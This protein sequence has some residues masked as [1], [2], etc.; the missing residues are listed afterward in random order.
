MR[1]DDNY[2]RSRAAGGLSRRRFLSSTAVGAAAVATLGLVGC[3]DDDNSESG[4]GGTS[5]QSPSATGTPKTASPKGQIQPTG[6][7][8]KAVEHFPLNYPA[9]GQPRK[10]GR[11]RMAS[12]YDLAGLDPTKSI[13]GGVIMHV[14]KAYNRLLQ[15][16]TGP[17]F[18]PTAFPG[19]VVPDLAASWE[20]PDAR[21]LVFKLSSGVKWQNVAPLNGR[22]FKSDDVVY[23]YQQYK[24]GGPASTYLRFTD[25]IEAVDSSTVRVT[26]K[27]P[28]ADQ[29]PYLA[30]R[31]L[32]IFPRELAESGE[33][34]NQAIGTGPMILKEARKGERM[35]W[36]RNPDYFGGTVWLDGIDHRIVSSG[37][38][39]DQLM[40]AGEVDFV[41]PASIRSKPS[42]SCSAPG[43]I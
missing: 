28:F 35:V 6:D 16:K 36:D 13:A 25:K 2:W 34:V 18:D 7:N 5:T 22:A 37:P 38:T 15:F 4:G 10:G 20:T 1:N 29:L 17:S 42:R 21:T 32:T 40:R 33:L 41:A 11:L 26:L 9:Q 3:G 12:N 24:A 23:A 19:E 27:E 39:R 8:L 31:Y 30:S 14:N 43:K